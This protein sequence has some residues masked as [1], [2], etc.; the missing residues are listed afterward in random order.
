MR[1]RRYR[2]VW[3]A[4]VVSLLLASA[5]AARGGR[6]AASP[7]IRFTV[8]MPK[9]HTHLL[10]VEMRIGGPAAQLPA[11][12]DLIMPVWTPGSYL[13]REYARH[14][15]DFT[16][17]DARGRALGWEKVNKTT[18]RVGTGGATELVVTYRVYANELSP[19]TNELNDRHAF[20]NHTAL[21]MYPE[22]E[23]RAPSTLRVVPFGDWKVATGLPAVAGRP[24]TFRADNFDTLYDSPV[25][26]GAFKTISFEVRG[27][28]HRIVIYGEGNYDAARVRA[29]VKKIAETEVAM[30]GEIPYSDYTFIMHLVPSGGGNATEHSNSVALTYNRFA[31]RPEAAY[32]GFLSLI[33]HE[34]F[35]LYNVKRIR[36]DAL[37]P[38]DYTRENYTKLLWVAEGTTEYYAAQALR[39]A[40]L[41]SEEEYLET[42]AATIQDVQSR[43]GRLQMSAEEASFDAWI[44]EY[45]PNENSANS[46]ISYYTKG[47]LLSMLLDL[48]IRQRSRGAKSLDD[49]LRYL[50]AEYYKKGRNYGPADFQRAC[51]LMAGASLEPF[52]ARYVSGREEL[53]YNAGLAA[54][55]FRLVTSAERGGRPAAEKAYLGADLGQEGDRL[56]VRRVYAGAPA[57]EQG[58]NVGDQIVALDGVRVTQQLFNARLSEKRPG[59]TIALSLFRSDDLRTL[60]L[61][62]GGRVDL[63]YGI[64]PVAQPSAEQSRLAREWLSSTEKQK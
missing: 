37:G 32:K 45:R 41:V 36:P 31:F 38:F 4:V 22:G 56:V 14:V 55:G 25:E 6:P 43:P 18:W 59:D 53:D 16:A 61:K 34:F 8:S 44:K 2:T 24:N 40:G 39:R 3:L 12:M 21:L 33:A 58:L 28:P 64:V 20:W 49:V 52:F 29:D 60:N 5:L 46:Q 63:S 50:Y 23:L 62:L 10:E 9:P 57:Y 42:L 15:Q 27:V 54:V 26:V 19:R 35:H 51:E 48:E 7:E 11:R 30:I 13:V 47:M 17:T 1:Y